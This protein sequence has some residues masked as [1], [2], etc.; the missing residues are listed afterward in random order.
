MSK[1]NNGRGANGRSVLKKSESVSNEEFFGV[2]P[3]IILDIKNSEDIHHASHLLATGENP[4]VAPFGNIIGYFSNPSEQAVGDLNEFKGRPRSQTGSITTSPGY[5]PHIGDWSKLDSTVLPKNKVLSL[6][7]DL[8]HMGPIGFILPAADFIPSHLSKTVN[9]SQKTVQLIVPGKESPVNEI[10]EGAVKQ[11]PDNPFIFATSGNVSS[12]LT[13]VEGAAHH[14]FGPLI[15]EFARAGKGGLIVLRDDEE[16][17]RRRHPFHDTRSTTILNLSDVVR[18]NKGNILTDK[19][20][21]PMISISRHGSA[22]ERYIR[23]ILAGQGFG[24]SFPK[25]RIPSRH[26]SPGEYMLYTFRHGANRMR[27]VQNP[28]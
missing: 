20:G 12:K 16:A 23:K 15:E 10:F 28:A 22:D 25:E 17:M 18:D 4:L 5:Y 7:Q 14:R 3:P 6:I 27:S 2:N 13:G 24:A 9:G 19:Q 11:M 1:F 26:Y 21:R 8:S